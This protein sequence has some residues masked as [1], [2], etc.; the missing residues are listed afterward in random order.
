MSFVMSSDGVYHPMG[1]LRYAKSTSEVVTWSVSDLQC[2]EAR[3]PK[4]LPLFYD[5]T[6][7]I[8]V[9]GMVIGKQLFFPSSLIFPTVQSSFFYVTWDPSG[10]SPFPSMHTNTMAPPDIS[11]SLRIF[12]RRPFRNR[13]WKWRA[14]SLLRIAIKCALNSPL[15]NV[16][17]RPRSCRG[18]RNKLTKYRVKRNV[19]GYNVFSQAGEL[20]SYT[21]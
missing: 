7:D 1:N 18:W 16:P 13:N 8:I 19:Q 15:S 3:L 10:Y 4:S 6:D 12:G 21:F 20:W 11:W 2:K 14:T 9:K 17:H 5:R